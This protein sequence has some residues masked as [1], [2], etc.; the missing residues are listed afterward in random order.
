MN[1]RIRI[2]GADPEALR[3][4]N[5]LGHL[6]RVFSLDRGLFTVLSETAIGLGADEVEVRDIKTPTELYERFLEARLD[7]CRARI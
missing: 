7:S 4:R 5:D 2:V 6:I 1:A 3:E